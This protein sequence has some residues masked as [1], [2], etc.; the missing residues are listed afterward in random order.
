MERRL[1]HW[2]RALAATVLVGAI[3]TV[4]GAAQQQQS[5]AAN[6][7]KFKVYVPS[8]ERSADA[9]GNF[10][11]DFA[12]ELR[13]LIAGMPRHEPVDRKEMQEALRK[14]KLVEDEMTC[15]PN[16]QLATHMQAELVVC[17]RWAGAAGS[18]RLDSMQVI[19]TK[20]QESFRLQQITAAT[21]KDAAAQSFAQIDK[22]IGT[23][24]NAAFCY[25]YLASQMWPQAL[26]NCNKALEVNPNSVRATMGKAFALYSQ[27][28]A[29]EPPD[30]AKLTEALTLYKKAIEI[31]TVP[32]QDAL[33][34]AG[35]IAARLSLNE[36]SRTYFRQYLDLNPGDAQV[37]LT[38]ANEQS[39]AGDKEGAL[40]VVEEGLKGDS[41]NLDLLTWAGV[42]A[43]QAAYQIHETKKGENNTL[44]PESKAL[45]ETAAMYYKRLFDVRNG[46]VEAAIPPQMMQT[47]YILDRHTEVIELGRR[48][49]SNP[50]YKTASLLNIMAQSLNGSGNT[51]EA[52][53]TLDEAIAMND[54][55]ARGMRRTKADIQLRAG[56]LAAA[57]TSYQAAIAAREVEADLASNMIFAT[58]YTSKF[59]QAKDYEGFLTY[60]DA[61]GQLAQGEGEKS[62]LSYWGGVSH[63]MIGRAVAGTEPTLATAKAALPRF[64]RAIRMMEA[65]ALY[66]RENNV[67]LATSLDALRKYAEYLSNRIKAGR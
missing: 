4:P 58:G 2:P 44:A 62:K 9:R 31:A 40:R 51:A 3:G 59:N 65:G 27:A 46:D 55:T 66:A 13:K 49:V 61:A 14:F 64:E 26:E 1:P 6:G 24:E 43:A 33:R 23:L 56:D 19:S 54:T 30:Q 45:F 28:V 29:N 5:A 25:D 50:K 18:F 41:A 53:T 39:K 57:V 37:R 38:I 17:G 67:N 35:I 32:E 20:T 60:L 12:N 52:I 34:M 21:A 42:F 36:E 11:K 48:L 22:Y 8:L 7:S 10:G 47:L 16:M 63:Q 15:I